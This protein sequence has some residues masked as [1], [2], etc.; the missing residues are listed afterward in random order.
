MTDIEKSSQNLHYIND[1][2]FREVVPNDP[3]IDIDG[4]E[5][6]VTN[7]KNAESIPER[8]AQAIDPKGN[9]LLET[10][11]SDALLFRPGAV[12]PYV[13][14]HGYD[15]RTGEWGHG[16]YFSDPAS[17]YEA[18]N[19]EIIEDATIRWEREDVREKL[20]EYGCAT[21]DKNIAKVLVNTQPGYKNVAEY[22]KEN[23]YEAG[24]A[25]LDETVGRLKEQ[26]VL[27]PESEAPA[28]RQREN[29]LH[30]KVFGFGFLDEAS[31]GEDGYTLGSEVKGVSAAKEELGGDVASIGTR[32]A[33]ER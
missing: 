14:A 2:K 15:G 18:A 28:A 22:M 9:V 11:G 13:V 27:V 10:F 4:V 17:A 7:V 32:S 16:T 5:E 6:I 1:L 12:Q 23:G 31:K 33:D 24:R 25:D 26:G 20:E 19:P 29:E 30:K 3:L 21:D 8:T